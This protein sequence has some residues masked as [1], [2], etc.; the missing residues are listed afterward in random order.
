MRPHPLERAIESN[1]RNAPIFRESRLRRFVSGHEIS[2][3]VKANKDMGF[4]AQNSLRTNISGKIHT[5]A[6]AEAQFS[7]HYLRPD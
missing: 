2:P 6:G 5:L 1:L 4:L 7:F 3:A